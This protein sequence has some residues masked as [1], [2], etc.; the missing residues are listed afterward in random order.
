MS[1][2][3]PFLIATCAILTIGFLSKYSLTEITRDGPN[4]FYVPDSIVEQF[5]AEHGGRWLYVKE[6]NTQKYSLAIKL[7][8]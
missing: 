2:L 1:F 3:F 5:E 4:S 8:E 6:S 7:G